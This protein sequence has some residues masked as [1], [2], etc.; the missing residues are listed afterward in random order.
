MQCC[1]NGQI[2]KLA[3]QDIELDGIGNE[4]AGCDFATG[5]WEWQ[6]EYAKMQKNWLPTSTEFLSRT[7]IEYFSC[8]VSPNDG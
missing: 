1:T 2:R 7:N 4:R 6:E 8:T 3:Y 5:I